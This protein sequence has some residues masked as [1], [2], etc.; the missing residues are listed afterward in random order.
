MLKPVLVI[1]N[2]ACAG[3]LAETLLQTGADVILASRNVN[4]DTKTPWEPKSRQSKN[5]E[6]HTGT[7]LVACSGTVGNFKIQLQ[8]GQGRIDRTVSAIIITAENR[9]RPNFSLYG[10]TPGQSV[11]ALTEFTRLIGSATP[12]NGRPGNANRIVFF[13]GLIQESHPVITEKIMRLC[14]SLQH[15]YNI[16]TYVLTGNLKVAAPGLEALYWQSKKAGTVYVKFTRG[17]P[18]IRQANGSVTVDFRD[19]ISGHSC[20]LKPDITVVDE[21]IVPSPHLAHLAEVLK[22]DMGPEGFLQTDNVRRRPTLTNRKGILALGPSRGVLSERDSLADAAGASLAISRLTAAIVDEPAGHAVIDPEKCIHCLTCFRLC[23][24]GAITMESQPAVAPES[25]ENCGLCISECPRRAIAATG[26]DALAPACRSWPDA[27]ADGFEPHLVAL[28][29][30]RS[31]LSAWKLSVLWGHRQPRR[32]SVMTLPCG[33]GV[34]K[35]LIYQLFLH[36]AD[37]VLVLTCHQGN[38]HSERG[39]RHASLKAGQIRDFFRQT[40][41]EAERLGVDTIAANMGAEFSE[42]AVRFADTIRNL[43][44]SRAK[45]LKDPDPKGGSLFKNEVN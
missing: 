33:A 12:E 42:K 19:E 44:P 39:Q 22:I 45:P 14:L 29:C 10:L 38:C 27:G 4:P 30:A 32:L 7:S 24:H 16:Q 13:T 36:G 5:P 41:F 37:G 40:G 8:N 11:L 17:S 31:A 3:A 35:D 25:C 21:T 18:R 6:V 2:G 34:S 23:P 1:G 9:F 26:A 43:G 28:C 20:E 15:T